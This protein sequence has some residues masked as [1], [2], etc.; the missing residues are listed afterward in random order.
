MEAK[1][2]KVSDSS[3]KDG[4]GKKRKHPGNYTP[5]DSGRS[6]AK[7]QWVLSPNSSTQKLEKR[8]N[9]DGENKVIV[10]ENHVEK[11]L[12]RYF[13]YYKKTGVPKRVMFHENGEWI[14]LPDHILCDIRND[15]EAKRATIEFNWCGRHFLLDF[16]HMYR[17]DLETGVKTQL[18]WIDI[19]GKCFFPETFDTL[20]RD[21]CHHIRGEDPEQHDQREIKLHIEIDVNSGELPRLN[22]NVVTDESGDNMDDFQAVQ[23]SSNGPNDE[24]SEDSCSRELD[25]AVE[26]WDK[27]ETDRFSGVKPAEEELDK[28]AV[29][30]M[31]ALGAATL[32]HVESLDVY[33][34]SSEI[35]KA[36]LS[37]F[38][39]QA[40]ITKKHRGDANIRYA[41]V[42][43]KKEVLSAVMMH[44]LGVGGA[45]I[46]KSMYG[47]GVHAANCPYFSARYCD[48]DDNGVRHMVLCRVIMGNME[49]LRG[50]NTQY[51]TGGEEYDNGVDDVES[52]KHYLIWNMNMNTHIYPEFVVSFKLSIPN[53]E[54][55]ILPTT[56]S[57]HESSGLTLEGPKGSPSNEPGRVSNGGSGSEKNSS[58]SR[59]P[60]SPI[61]PFP[62]LFKAISSKIAR[63]DMDLI[64]AGYQELRE[65]K[66]SRKEFYKTLSMIVGDDDLLISTI[67][68]LQRS[69][70]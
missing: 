30:Q 22:L 4:L 58:S 39:K 42:P 37:L 41:W 29:K 65:K 66:V 62:L 49:P 38:Q 10:S 27:T 19:A 50:D 40:D 7:L 6:Y 51:F 48:I 31:F 53:A 44:G 23:R 69:L 46:K 12:V 2:V 61:M 26:K 13:S 60:R 3:Y 63:K 28:D 25:D 9:L 59:R 64:I 67:T 1:I 8:R 54:G 24:A 5:Y 20:E 52:P 36:R 43:A 45:F 57:R 55:N 33:Q 47:V 35:A 16:L 14:D 15:L 21:G 56:Q 32:G 11:S 34:F 68:G 18:A 70:G 17:L